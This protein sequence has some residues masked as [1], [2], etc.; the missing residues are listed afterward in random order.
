LWLFIP[1]M[2]LRSEIKEHSQPLTR[3]VW[4]LVTGA[5][6]SQMTGASRSFEE[7]NRALSLH[8]SYIQKDSWVQGKS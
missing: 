5:G 7:E 6:R 4:I 8:S 1:H 2:L 3:G